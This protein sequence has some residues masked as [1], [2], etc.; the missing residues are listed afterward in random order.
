MTGRKARF[1]L[2]ALCIGLVAA[3]A[4]VVAVF[5]L[6]GNSPA[7]PFPRLVP[8]AAPAGWAQL[9]LPNGTAVLSYPPSLHPVSGDKDA[10]SVASRSPAGSIVLYLN[11]TPKQG[12][13]N[14][15]N[16]AAF[17]L[18][19]LRSDDASSA[20]EDSAATGIDFRG[21]T[22]S[23]VMDDYITRIGGHHYQEIACFAQGRTGAS[24]IVAAAAAAQWR[25]AWPL[26]EQAVA[27][28]TVR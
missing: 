5:V 23:C 14:L 25:Q 21:G 7:A 16:W 15:R 11:A 2:L 22:G 1:G 6:P 28:Y 9:T 13:E 8:K 3:V 17:R 24:V 26:L 19:R 4:A 18:S 10:V 20:H 12:G 27:A